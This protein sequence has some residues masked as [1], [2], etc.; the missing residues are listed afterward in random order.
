MNHA[1]QGPMNPRRCFRC[2]GLGSVAADCPNH[3]V[4]TLAEWDAVKEEVAKEEK[5]ASLEALEEEEEE[6]IAE[7][8]EGN[9]SAS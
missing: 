8:D 2:Q 6:V 1:N 9:A 7:A 3:R 4:I 5:E